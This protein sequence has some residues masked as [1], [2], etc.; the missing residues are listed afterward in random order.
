M[1]APPNLSDDFGVLLDAGIDDWGG[2]SPITA[3]HVN[4][5]RPWPALDLLRAVT[6]SR[7]PRAGAPA[8]RLPRLRAGPRS[9][10]STRALRFAVMDRS[11]AE[12]LAR[13]D[14]GSV[15]PQKVGEYKNVGDGAEVVLVGRRSTQWYSGADVHPPTLLPGTPRAGRRSRAR[16]STGVRLGQEA[17]VDELVDPLLGPGP[18]RWQPWPGWPTSCGR[19]RSVTR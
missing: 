12:G 2:V 11:D 10:G 17:G 16:Y 15:F 9:G 19:R 6:E 4:P 14:P 3:D 1:Q 7:R 8:H 5:E 18:A 13:D